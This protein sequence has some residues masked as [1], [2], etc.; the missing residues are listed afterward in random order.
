MRIDK[1]NLFCNKKSKIVFYL[2]VIFCYEFKNIIKE[3][4]TNKHVRLLIL[5]YELKTKSDSVH[6]NDH[7]KNKLKL[8]RIFYRKFLSLCHNLI[9]KRQNLF[10]VKKNNFIIQ[11]FWA[12]PPF[13][14][15]KW[16]HRFSH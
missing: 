6:F 16:A 4:F 15:Q 12:Q 9:F 1:V 3:L 2:S 10:S 8:F 14:V 11:N 7:I 13:W 5:K